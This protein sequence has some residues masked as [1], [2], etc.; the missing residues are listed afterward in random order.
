MA[1]RASCKT[2]ENRDGDIIAQLDADHQA[3]ATT[4]SGPEARSPG[5]IAV[6]FLA[7]VRAGDQ[8]GGQTSGRRP[9]QLDAV[10]RQLGGD[11]SNPANVAPLNL[12]RAWGG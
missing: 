6:E 11:Q 1:D 5:Q 2:G 4:G 3:G 7:L 8:C 12:A 9:T 10:T